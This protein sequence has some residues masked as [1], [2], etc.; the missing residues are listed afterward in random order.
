MFD[1]KNYYD[2][3]KKIFTDLKDNNMRADYSSQAYYQDK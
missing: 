1:Q 3:F 2:E